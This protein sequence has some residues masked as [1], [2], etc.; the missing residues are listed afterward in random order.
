[1]ILIWRID[2]KNKFGWILISLTLLL[3]LALGS[4]VAESSVGTAGTWHESPGILVGPVCGGGS[5]GGG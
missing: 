1:M 2:M 4:V 3:V 5:G